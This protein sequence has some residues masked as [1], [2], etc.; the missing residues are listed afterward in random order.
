MVPPARV[1]VLWSTLT[2]LFLEIIEE[3]V[4]VNAWEMKSDKLSVEG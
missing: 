2:L 3:I 1:T 4:E